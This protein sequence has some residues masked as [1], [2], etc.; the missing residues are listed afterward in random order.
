MGLCKDC[1]HW[2]EV[3]SAFM[4]SWQG[5]HFCKAIPGI[6]YDADV[7]ADQT[8]YAYCED[9]FGNAVLTITSH[10]FGCNKFEAKSDA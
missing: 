3:T 10:D 8:T 4:R 1:R 6:G 2:A 7:E 5:L 9:S